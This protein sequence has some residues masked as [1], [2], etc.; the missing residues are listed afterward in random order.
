MTE[1]KPDLT[2]TQRLS[3]RT[4]EPFFLNLEFEYFFF[5]SKKKYENQTLRQNVGILS[6]FT[7]DLVAGLSAHNDSIRGETFF[8]SL[9]IIK[10]VSSFGLLCH[11]FDEGGLKIES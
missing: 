7:T 3:R 9:A 4:E 1:R 5:D 8:S 10:F 6:N 2:M 11:S